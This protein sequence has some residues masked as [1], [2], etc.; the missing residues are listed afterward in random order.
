MWRVTLLLAAL[1]A[2][3][4]LCA[5]P[6]DDRAAEGYAPAA[7]ELA[8]SLVKSD[9]ARARLLLEDAAGK[10][11]PQ[12][13]L[14]LAVPG[15]LAETPAEAERRLLALVA[16]GDIEAARIGC[17]LAVSTRRGLFYRSCMAAAGRGDAQAQ[18][19]LA[20]VLEQRPDDFPSTEETDDIRRSSGLKAEPRRSLI[21]YGEAAAGGHA[22]AAA[23]LALYAAAGWSRAADEADARR[24]AEQAAKAENGDGLAVLGL[25]E[26][27]G[28]DARTGAAL[29]RQGAEKGSA[30][31]MLWLAQAHL[32]GQGVTKD[33]GEAAKWLALIRFTPGLP[34]ADRLKNVGFATPAGTREGVTSRLTPSER[35]EAEIRA[36]ELRLALAKSGAWP[37]SQP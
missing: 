17:R 31:A 29:L 36:A 24:F 10:G 33:A 3:A 23:R 18:Y 30:L 25:L 34:P 16:S 5:A 20:T 19:V 8:L 13:L 6:F 28:G 26:T 37:V 9:P 12:A 15:D 27:K 21:W 7:T 32:D 22:G 1:V 2:P 4:A 35:L 14:L 11:E